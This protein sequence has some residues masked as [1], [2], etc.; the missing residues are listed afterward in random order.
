[1]L[2]VFGCI[3]Q[4]HDLRLVAEAALICVLSCGTTLNLMARAQNLMAGGQ[5]GSRN[6]SLVWIALAATVFGSGVWSL[7]FVAM[8]AFT[9]GVPIAY[10]VPI[11]VVSA[12]VAIAGSLLA[13]S[14]WLFS[15]TRLGRVLLA[16]AL[17][18]LAVSAMHYCGVLAMRLPGVLHFDRGQVA[19]SIAVS[20][21]FAIL[22]LRRSETLALPWRRVEAGGWLTLSICGLHFTGMSALSIELGPGSGSSND[23]VLGTQELAVM[24]GSVSLAILLVSL[25]A[26]L[27]EQRLSRRA[28]LELKRM[29]LMS[30]ISQEVLIIVRDGNIL[31]IN[32]AGGRMFAEPEDR[33][34]GR[35]VLDLVL[36]AD[37]AAVTTS[38]GNGGTKSNPEE[39]H[40][41]TMTGVLIPV[42]FSCA[43]ID[44]DAGPALMMALRDLSDRK[45]DEARIRHLAHHDALT[46]L[47]NR[48]LLQ[49]R[50]THA[51]AA[52]RRSGDA[53][54]LLYLDLDRFKPVNDLQG[55]AAGDE[56]LKQVAGRLLGE[57]RSAD[58]VARI[59]GDEFVIVAT[60]DEPESLP[61]LA[62]RLIEA[63]ARP[64]TL[65][66]TSV[67]IGTSIGIAFFPRDGDSQEALLHAA[68]TALYRAKQDGR[69]SFRCFEPIMD[70]HLQ[71]RRKLEQDLR[72]ALERNQLQVHYQP[73]VS[74][75][76]GEVEGFEALLRW[77]HP[78]LGLVP[79]LEFI[80][81]AEEIGV[82]AQIGQWVLETACRAAAG[83]PAPCW[84]AVNVSPVQ[85]RQLDLP[86]IIADILVRSGLPAHRL[87]IELTEGVLIEDSRRAADIL[88]AL[89][90]QGVRVALDDFGT[91]YSSLSYLHALKLDKLKIDRSFIARLGENDGS[92]VIVRSII[93]LAHSLGLSIVAEGVENPR[94]LAI[95]RDLMCDQVQGYLLGRPMATEGPVELVAARA[96]NLLSAGH[97]PID[98]LEPVEAPGRRADSSVDGVGAVL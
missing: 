44:Y 48:F 57:L 61:K 88:A 87:E 62:G 70:E 82:I 51:M 40:V 9:P 54:A 52:S 13:F 35:C 93:S 69:G 81:L 49:E 17:V 56:V 31:E 29:R 64:F 60:V 47:P 39:I 30:D 41:R 34:I 32:A 65:G 16:G 77:H 72:H 96:R 67:E 90:K 24:V 94:Q 18:G 76:T 19:A 78:E 23:V 21:G 86:D 42:E 66:H 98:R 27:M 97:K 11:T 2:R 36:Q 79:P 91:G 63:I 6:A 80:P 22:A 8:L 75:A 59:G 84:V 4:Q 5:T 45:R 85:F 20:I 53:L 33:L 92:T 12:L 73:V 1:M 71:I 25:A 46:G 95:V 38:I 26:T 68:D 74:C 28:V 50:L 58:T 37:R 15:R 55:H 43:V 3:T 89:R 14:V 7:H 83:W 10:S